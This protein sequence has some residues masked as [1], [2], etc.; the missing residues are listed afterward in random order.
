M[1]QDGRLTIRCIGRVQSLDVRNLNPVIAILLQSL[2]DHVGLQFG[3]AVE[4]IAAHEGVLART[5]KAG[6][7][8]PVT[9]DPRPIADINGRN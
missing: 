3:I 2:R 1:R 4:F 8:I 9:S 5:A 6:L 7:H